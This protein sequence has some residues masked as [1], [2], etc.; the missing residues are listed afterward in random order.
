MSQSET[1]RHHAERARADADSATLENVKERL[2]RAESAWLAMANR[3]ESVDRA[4]AQ[5]E[6]AQASA[7]TLQEIT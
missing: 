6:N 1:Y 5:R 3:Q 7:K 4:R 2:L